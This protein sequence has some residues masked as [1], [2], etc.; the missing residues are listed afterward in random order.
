MI[1][2]CIVTKNNENTI[3]NCLKSIEEIN[4]KIYFTDINSTDNTKN[5]L[6]KFIEIP[7]VSESIKDN[8]N[9]L[10][11][12]L[13]EDFLF[14]I[15]PW[16]EIISGK[17]EIENI[18]LKK[19]EA[20]KVLILN[21]EIINKSIRIVGKNKEIKFENPIY[22]QIYCKEAEILNIFLKENE[23]KF[24][25]EEE[26]I[27]QW[28][29]KERFNST[30]YYYM[31][32][33]SLK[34]KNYIDFIKY[35]EK[36]L[37]ME[38]NKELPSII[39]THYYMSLINLHVFKNIKKSMENIIFCIDKKPDMAEFWCILGDINFCLKKYQKSIYFYENAINFGK[40]RKENDEFSIEIKK[41]KIYPDTMIKKCKNLI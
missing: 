31:L 32:C 28:I 39:M 12:L 18:K 3:K 6:K 26:R 14:F 38:K 35:S 11:N 34:N 13:E 19:Q 17:K 2:F 29:N 20:Y 37:F 23:V 22:E 33:S 15:D 27:K 16:E 40:Y 5:Y 36:Y 21:K 30:P 9:N 7:P 41:Y 10:I 4:C 25:K 8:K 24:D 1:A